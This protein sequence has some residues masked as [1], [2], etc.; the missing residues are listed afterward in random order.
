MNGNLETVVEVTQH[1]GAHKYIHKYKFENY[2]DAVIFNIAANRAKTTSSMIL[3]EDY[4]S[5]GECKFWEHIDTKDGIGG[6]FDWGYCH[7]VIDRAAK[8]DESLLDLSEYFQ[9]SEN[10]FCSS[11]ERKED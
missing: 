7:K 11:F 1:S 4:P 6:S 3:D 2:N 10:E 9:K 8:D 5:C